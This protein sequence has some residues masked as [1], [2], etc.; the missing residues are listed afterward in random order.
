MLIFRCRALDVDYSFCS[1]LLNRDL[2]R[3]CLGCMFSLRFS[4]NKCLINLRRQF[5]VPKRFYEI[6]NLFILCLKL[7]FQKCVT[8]VL[9]FSF[10]I[11]CSLTSVFVLVN[12][13][14][15]NRS[16]G[17]MIKYLIACLMN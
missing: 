8:F 10:T 12:G 13:I 15:C 3:G 7:P 16:N 11:T 6:C 17:L 9:G 14:V 5:R 1:I 4:G 2:N